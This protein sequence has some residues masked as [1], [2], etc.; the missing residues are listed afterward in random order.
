VA[1]ALNEAQPAEQQAME[2]HGRP[3]DR[4]AMV[5]FG[6]SGDL[7]KRK[8]LPSLY[9]LAKKELLPRDFALVGCAIDDISEEEFRNRVH[10]DL[11]EFGNAAEHCRFC[12]WILERLHYLHGDF[13]D[14]NTYERLKAALGKVDQQHGTNGN[15]FYYLAT[16]PTLW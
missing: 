1:Q 9:N 16:T 3:A 14:P 15:Y 2:R 13:H 10:A 12:D 11:R 8:L 5:I 4:C 6:A 7:T